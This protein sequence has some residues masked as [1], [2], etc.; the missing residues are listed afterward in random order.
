MQRFAANH[1]IGSTGIE[2]AVRNG[3]EPGDLPC[4]N[5]FNNL[6]D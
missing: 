3:D 6:V 1:A 2:K 4:D 5:S